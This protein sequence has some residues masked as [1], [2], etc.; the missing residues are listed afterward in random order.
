MQKE[1]KDNLTLGSEVF[2]EEAMTFDGAASLILTAGG[3]YNFT[4]NFAL[5]FSGGHSIAGQEHLLGYLGLYWS[6]GKD[7]SSSLNKMHKQASSANV[8]GAHKNL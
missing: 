7:S 8:N 2:Y 3:I 6:F 5:Q 4:K 1:V